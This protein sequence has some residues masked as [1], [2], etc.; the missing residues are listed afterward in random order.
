MVRWFLDKDFYVIPCGAVAK[1]D[2]PHGRIVHNYSRKFDGLSLNE[3]LIDNS[4]SYISFK[5]RARLLAKVA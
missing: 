5:D 1:G 4:V 3:V 2:N